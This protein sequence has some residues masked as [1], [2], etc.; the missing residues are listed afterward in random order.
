MIKT[1]PIATPCIMMHTILSSPT[2]MFNEIENM[3]LKKQT[4]I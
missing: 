3:F 1:I 2:L 4:K